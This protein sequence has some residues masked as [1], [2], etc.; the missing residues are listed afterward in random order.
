MIRPV[1][2]IAKLIKLNRYSRDF[3]IKVDERKRAGLKFKKKIVEILRFK[4][5]SNVRKGE[6]VGITR[7]VI[8][9]TKY[10]KI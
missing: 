3:V 4:K 5:K 7:D 2:S 1:M 6:K 9:R 8:L 10:C